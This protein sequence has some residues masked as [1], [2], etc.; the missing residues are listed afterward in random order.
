MELFKLIKEEKEKEFFT[1]IN[2][3]T[4]DINIKDE[5]SYNLL[6]ISIFKGVKNIALFLI[7]KGIDLS[8][9]DKNG[10][11]ALHHLAVFY[12]KE[13]LSRIINKG[14]DVNIIDKFGNQPLWATVFN[15][16][17]F[18]VRV[19]MA[20]ILIKN[21]ANP[22]HRNNVGKSPLEI[23]KIAGYVEIEK[24]LNNSPVFYD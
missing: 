19:E 11:T 9:Q 13:I 14:V 6:M 12:N 21:R 17:G 5:D 24:V 1:E 7:D 18:G 23:S 15:D 4:Y 20:E 8:H 2:E 3:G 16:K 10:Q 22:N